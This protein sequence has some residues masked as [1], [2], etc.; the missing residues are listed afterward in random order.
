MY[1]IKIRRRQ[2]IQLIRIQ[3]NFTSYDRFSSD[4][5]FGRCPGVNVDPIWN[6]LLLL[7]MRIAYEPGFVSDKKIELLRACIN[8]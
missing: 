2:T 1:R 6:N 3:L 7:L 4:Y 5:Q 8:E